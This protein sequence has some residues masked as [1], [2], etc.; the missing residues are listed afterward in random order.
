MDETDKLIILHTMR[1]SKS[2]ST[3]GTI[4]IVIVSKAFY[5]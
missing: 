2:P 5:I 3:I 4:I 1:C